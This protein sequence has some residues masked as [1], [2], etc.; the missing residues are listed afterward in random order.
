MWV[1]GVGDLLAIHDLEV[2]VVAR[3]RQPASG[4]GELYAHLEVID[5]ARRVCDG[6][7]DADDPALTSRVGALEGDLPAELDEVARH[8]TALE[9]TC[10][11]VGA[12]ALG[13][14]GEVHLHTRVLLD[15]AHAVEVD[16]VE[17]H[18]GADA[19]DG[20]G[21]DTVGLL[22]LEAEA[23]EVDEWGAG[24]VI[25]PTC[26]ARDDD[27]LQEDLAQHR[28]HELRLIAVDR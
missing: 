23:P 18:E 20:F 4:T 22:L 21:G 10:H 15:H 26:V 27:G 16:L 7:V 28:V 1:D 9:H 11:E 8:A 3:G 14:G 25:A 12:V 24:H 19:V 6:L 2:A 13:D 5:D 17:A